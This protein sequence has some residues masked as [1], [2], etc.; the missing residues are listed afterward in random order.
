MI[1]KNWTYTISKYFKIEIIRYRPINFSVN[2]VKYEA[3]RFQRYAAENT[4]VT[5]SI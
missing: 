1:L 4:Y 5:S 2:I 3:H